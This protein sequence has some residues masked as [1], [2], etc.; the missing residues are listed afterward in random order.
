VP[1]PPPSQPFVDSKS[2]KSATFSPHEETLDENPSKVEIVLFEEH[3][4]VE[5]NSNMEKLY[6][7]LYLQYRLILL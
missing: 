6:L 5:L 3:E 2:F 1:G 4:P 7:L